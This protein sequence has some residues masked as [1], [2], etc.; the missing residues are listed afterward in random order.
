M[1]EVPYGESFEAPLIVIMCLV[2]A[3]SVAGVVW[4]NKAVDTGCSP[5]YQTYCGEHHGHHDDDHHDGQKDPH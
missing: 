4:L 2:M 3:L 5:S 1:A